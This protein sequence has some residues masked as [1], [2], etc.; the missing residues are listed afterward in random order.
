MKKNLSRTGWLA[1]AALAIL[2]LQ[3][4]TAVA[5]STV[6]TYQGRVLANGTNFNGT[7]QFKFALITSSTFNQQATATANLSGQF[8][9]SYHIL[10]RGSGYVNAPSVTVS[11]GGCG[12]TDAPAVSIQ[13]GG[14]SGATATAVVNNGVVVNMVIPDAGVGHTTAPQIVIG[15]PPFVPT[16]SIPVRKVNVTE[17]VVLGRHCVLESSADLVTW[18]ATG[19]LFTAQ[20]ETIVNKFDVDVTGRF[21]RIRQVPQTSQHSSLLYGLS[22]C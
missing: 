21:F 10:S 1:L 16:V 17:T 3:P 22:F 18:T 4:A 19:P 9:T 8:V 6:F 13:G 14:G 5:Q 7:G 20:A 11:G 15:S 2:N 12:D